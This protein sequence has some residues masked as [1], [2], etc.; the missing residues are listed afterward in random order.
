MRTIWM[1]LAACSLLLLAGCAQDSGSANQNQNT[2]VPSAGSPTPAELAALP[3]YTLSDVASHN[4][5]ADCWVAV[6]ASV[7]NLTGSPLLARNASLASL[8]GADATSSFGSMMG[9]APGVNFS[10]NA[11]RGN[12]SGNTGS[13][14]MNGGQPSSGPGGYGNGSYGGGNR[15]GMMNGGFGPM[16]IGRLV[17]G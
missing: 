11:T 8:C 13:R 12:F 16:M 1:M 14:R 9:R 5:P 6:N 3:T 17:G 10:R 2:E 15:T 7:L 4:T